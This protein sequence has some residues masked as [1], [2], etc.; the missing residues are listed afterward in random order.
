MKVLKAI[1]IGVFFIY[2]A[3]PATAAT[4]DSAGE[5]TGRSRRIESERGFGVDLQ[6]VSAAYPNY[7]FATGVTN[8]KAALG[9][10]MAFEWLVLQ[11]YGKLGVGISAGGTVNS[12]FAV[13]DTAVATLYTFPL[14]AYVSYHLDF[15]EN[16]WVVPFG[17]LGANVTIAAQRSNQG[18]A[19]AGTQ[20]FNGLDIGGG[21]QLNLNNVEKSAARSLDETTGINTTYLIGEI[22][23]TSGLSSGQSPDL[24]RTE[25]R[26]GL[27]FEM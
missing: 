18:M 13:T 7:E 9:V 4:G 11:S 26:I 27:R 19:R 1:A 16:Q 14:G 2:G 24:S 12:N 17:K 3:L 15:F 20:S 8:P 23:K 21:I 22:V 10:R 6:F 5:T 25:Y